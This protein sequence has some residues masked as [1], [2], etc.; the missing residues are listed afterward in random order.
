MHTNT[1]TT[2][3]T[4]TTSILEQGFSLYLQVSSELIVMSRLASNLVIL[5]QPSECWDYKH[6]LKT[7]GPLNALMIPY[8]HCVLKL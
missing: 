1:T 7:P 2:T 3:T 8:R 5:L 6:E 4:S